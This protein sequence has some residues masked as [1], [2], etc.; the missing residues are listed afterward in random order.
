MEPVFMLGKFTKVID[1]FSD[2]GV[3]PQTVEPCQ[4]SLNC[5]H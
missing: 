5:S 2:M 1:Y 3:P 4:L